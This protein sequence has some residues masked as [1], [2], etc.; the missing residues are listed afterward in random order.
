MTDKPSDWLQQQS[1]AFRLLVA[2]THFQPPS[3]DQITGLTDALS[4]DDTAQNFVHLAERHG[5]PGLAYRR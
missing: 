3:A 2:L 4:N 5:L 1:P